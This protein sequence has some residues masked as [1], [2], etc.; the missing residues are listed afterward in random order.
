ML[1]KKTLVETLLEPLEDRV[2]LMSLDTVLD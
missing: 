1:S 2:A